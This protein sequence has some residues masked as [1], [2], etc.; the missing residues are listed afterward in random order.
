VKDAALGKTWFEFL[1]TNLL[2]DSSAAMADTILARMKADQSLG[3]VFPDDPHAQGWNNN[4]DF[5]EALARKIGLAELP[6]HFNFPVGTMFWAR[7]S[8][9]A[10][11]IRLNF[12][13]DDYPAEPL[14]YDGTLL[15]AIERLLPLTLPVSLLHSATTNVA[16]TTR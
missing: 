8:A 7:T 9:L 3:I 6:E 10:P 4:R 13:W 1:M 12:Q 14:K 11:L 2:G 5:A 16:G 15:H